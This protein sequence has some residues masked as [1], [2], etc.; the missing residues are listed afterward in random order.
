M[1]P[2]IEI[3]NVTKTYGKHRGVDGLSF[4]VEEGDIFAFLG[5]NG[6]G[7]STTIRSMLGML[8]YEGDIRIMGKDVRIQ[9]TEILKETGYMPSEAMF[10]P[11]M[12]VKDV[13]RF[14]ADM[15][16][17]DCRE[18]A[19][20]LCERLQVDVN[21]KIQELSLGNRKKVSIIC[22]MQHA[23]RLLVLDEPT[24][25]L[26]PLMQ[27]TFFQLLKETNVKGT[28]CF[29]SSHVLSE[30]KKY[31]RNAAIIREGRILKVDSVE[32]L[33]HTNLRLIKVWKDGKEEHF[34]HEGA[35][36]E[37]LTRLKNMEPD[38]VLIEEPSLE[39]M[40][41]QFYED[42]SGIKR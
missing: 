37:L 5:P 9:K 7:K 17:R 1:A 16:K 26:D 14:A 6:A 23:P 4:R 35:M 34:T 24:S 39:E 13:I 19:G 11:S 2:I 28:T 18:E 42:R 36:A 41:M 29:L 25:G 3:T 32:N 33:S 31:C 21:K 20:R 22:A 10:Y 40:F 8:Q 12:K 15:H 30:V 38:D 27:D